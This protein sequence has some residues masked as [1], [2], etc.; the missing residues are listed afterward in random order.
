MFSKKLIR[1]T[2]I[3]NDTKIKIANTKKYKFVIKLTTFKF[4]AK[5]RSKK[6]VY[7]KKLLST[8]VTR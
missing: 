4:I 2:L 8:N 7:S 5:K 6:K 3:N 1:I